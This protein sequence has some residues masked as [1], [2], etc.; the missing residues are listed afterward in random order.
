MLHTTDVVMV[1]C[2]NITNFDLLTLHMRVGF[3]KQR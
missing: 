1:L 2:N 3:K